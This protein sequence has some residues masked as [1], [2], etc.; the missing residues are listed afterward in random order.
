[1]DIKFYSV[2]LSDRQLI[3][4]YYEVY[5]SNS[6]ADK[7]VCGETESVCLKIN[8]TFYLI[9]TPGKFREGEIDKF[10]AELTTQFKT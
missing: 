7:L 2:T 9:Q 8:G 10:K 5:K 3:E 1:M 6:F 4:V